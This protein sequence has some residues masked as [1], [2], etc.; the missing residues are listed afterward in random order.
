[1]EQDT[2]DGEK[3]A[4]TKVGFWMSQ[5]EAAKEMAKTSMDDAEDS[6]KE[7]TAGERS[8]K[9][10][11]K[12]K[13]RY[14]IWWSSIRTVQPAIYSRTPIVVSEKAF[15][16]MQDDIGRLAAICLERFGKFLIRACPFDRVQY[17]TRDQFLHAGKT[18]NRVCFESK[19]IKSTAKTYYTPRET[20]DEMGEIVMSYAD[21]QGNMLPEDAQ[22]GQDEQGFYSETESEELDYCKVDLIPT[23]FKDVLHTPNA[24]WQEEID[25]IAYR[26]LMTKDDCVERFGDEA[27]ELKYTPLGDN[28]RDRAD[29]KAIPSLYTTIWEIWDKREK[30][31]YWLSEGKKDAFLDEKDDP[32]K[33]INF[34]P[35]PAFM[36]GTIGTENMYTVPDYVQLKPLIDQLHG[37]AD[38]FR[39]LVL[40]A[41]K[42]GMAD[43]AVDELKALEGID[44][45]DF[46]FVKNFKQLIGDGGLD[47][48]VK[49]FPTAEIVAAI[50]TMAEVLGLY[51]AKFNEMMGIPDILRGVSDPRETAAAQ[52]QKGHYISL[53][54]SAI[55]REFQRLVRDDIEL[56]LDLAL[57]MFPTEKIASICGVKYMNEREQMIW[58]QALEMMRNDT[59]R[60]VRITIETDSTITM[61]QNAD[62]EQRNYLAKTLFD[63]IT[64]IAKATQE[65]PEFVPV[66]M[67]AV[68]YVVR[69]LQ[70]GKQIE[71]T[72]Q[73]SLQQALAPKPQQPPPPD[74]AMVKAQAQIQTTQMKA[75]A[76]IQSKQMQVQADIQQKD[77]ATQAEIVREDRKAQQQAQLEQQDADNDMA[78]AEREIELKAMLAQVQADIA[79][80]KA[81]DQAEI[82]LI[83]AANQPTGGGL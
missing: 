8:S 39:R 4:A 10:E 69:G 32:Y 82:A 1:M 53:R 52:Q 7:F 42:R 70:Q 80:Q 71:E 33:L 38:R 5:I 54:F 64:A 41:K 61:N 43:A 72:L 74:P 51:E 16:T 25:W 58:P 3:A 36:L 26:S 30:R 44:E 34:F 65:A 35:S 46:I 21:E 81:N 13:S 45:A 55:Q 31:V 78:L 63:G 22:L 6:V 73:R 67:E 47:N 14:P 66:V 77:M 19:F 24:R 12:P 15:D 40:A 68:L 75:Q 18:T 48:L 28:D 79:R 60:Q 83:K 59:E 50:Q 76:D 9:D 49:Y 57:K 17:A 37:C 20:T 29:K 56:M 62:I 11:I 23:H 2:E 27:N